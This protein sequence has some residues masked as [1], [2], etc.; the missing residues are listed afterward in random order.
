[1][2]KRSLRFFSTELHPDPL[3]PLGDR[4]LRLYRTKDAEFPI[5][6]IG[7]AVDGSWFG[8]VVTLAGGS[9]LRV[10]GPSLR[11]VRRRL[12][13]LVSELAYELRGLVGEP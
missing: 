1:M 8:H 13:T 9:N 3:G 10:R 7:E 6:S 4:V 11:A 5:V 12:Q 2:S